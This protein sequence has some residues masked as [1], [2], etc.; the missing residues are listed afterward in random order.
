MIPVEEATRKLMAKAR[1]LG[2]EEVPVLKALGRVLREDVT[3][4]F[5]IPP[6]SKS[7]M[8]G[9]AVRSADVRGASQESPV[10]LSVLE[11]VPA[12]KVGRHRVTKGTAARIMTG[13]PIPPGADAIVMVEYT[14]PRSESV[15]IMQAAPKGTHVAPRG[16][17][18]RKGQRV[19]QAGAMIRA[20]EMG[21][22]NKITN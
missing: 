17:D 19:L 14:E 10:E 8:D 21:M 16:E 15:L 5:P 1:P 9:Y 20:A 22:K 7:A 4:P 11:D 6:F 2:T 3:S 13:A 12:G 18:V